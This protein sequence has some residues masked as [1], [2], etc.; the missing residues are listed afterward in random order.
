MEKVRCLIEPH[1]DFSIEWDSDYKGSVATSKIAWGRMIMKY[2][3]TPRFLF[4]VSKN[5]NDFDFLTEKQ[6]KEILECDM[7][8]FANERYDEIARKSE[9]DSKHFKGMWDGSCVLDGKRKEWPEDSL[10]FWRSR[11]NMMMDRIMEALKSKGI[12]PEEL[13]YSGI[14]PPSTEYPRCIHILQSPEKE[15]YISQYWQGVNILRTDEKDTKQ[16][17]SDIVRKHGVVVSG[18]LRSLLEKLSV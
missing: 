12:K 11:D 16:I 7:V 17:A 10:K 13:N 15:T 1:Y 9:R 6:K 5:L 3:S 18:S 8:S 4:E 14:V 2:S